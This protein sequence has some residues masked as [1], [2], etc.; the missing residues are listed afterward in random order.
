MILIFSM[1]NFLI[2]M[3]ILTL[4]VAP[5]LLNNI[6]AWTLDVELKNKPFGDDSAF[7]KIRGPDGWTNSEW[8][9]WSN[10]KSGPGTA[11][12]TWYLSENDFPVGEQY[13]VCVSSKPGFALFPYCYNF[14]HK[15]DHERVSVSLN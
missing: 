9:E 15:Y 3:T 5:I 13:Q 10:I 6:F 4:V 8:Y 1:I 14:I 12:V 7:V 11:S 2:L